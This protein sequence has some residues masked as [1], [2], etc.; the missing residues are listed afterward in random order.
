MSDGMASDRG[1]RYWQT[2]CKR[3][4]EENIKLREERDA[5][6]CKG[7]VVDY[8]S[9]AD[10]LEHIHNV[11]RLLHE[12]IALL[13]VRANEHDA[14]KLRPP[15]KEAFDRVTP[16]LRDTTYGSPEYREHLQSIQPA[17]DHH[18]WVNE[19]H[20]E[21]WVHGI[22]GMSLIDLVEMLCDWKAASLRHADGDLRKSI[23]INRERFNMSPQLVRILLNTAERMQWLTTK[24]E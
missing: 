12:C 6:H 5:S 13:L 21:H 23:E 20:P 18:N 17:I 19:H 14:S 2:E 10:T 7:G 11:S 24:G 9:K 22:M 3:L 4:R 8:D 15:E 1:I 16:L